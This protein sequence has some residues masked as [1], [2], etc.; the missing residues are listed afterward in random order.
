VPNTLRKTGEVSI[1]KLRLLK[2][3]LLSLKQT[4]RFRFSNTF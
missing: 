1:K 4:I 2:V 3:A